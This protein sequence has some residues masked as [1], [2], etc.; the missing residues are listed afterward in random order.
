[1]KKSKGNVKRYLLL[2][3]TKSVDHSTRR[4][5]GHGNHWLSVWNENER[6]PDMFRQFAAHWHF[7]VFVPAF[8]VGDKR[9]HGYIRV[10]P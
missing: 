8:T 4:Q 3:Y 1:M 7:E 6:N 5:V 9:L 2:L 10:N